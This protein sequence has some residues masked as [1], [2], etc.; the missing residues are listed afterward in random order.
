LTVR[1][2]QR[3][4]G[5]SEQIRLAVGRAV[6]DLLAEG[7]VAFTTVE[8]AERAEVNRRT[9]YRWWPTQELLLIEAL[10]QHARDIEVPDTGSLAR[11]VRAFARRVAVFAADP[12]DLTITRIMVAG[13][14]PEFNNAVTEHFRPIMAGWEDLFARAVARG[15]A[16]DEHEPQAIVAALVSPLFLGPLMSGGTPLTPERVD[17]VA[18]LV[19]AAVAR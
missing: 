4:G 15:E 11:D 17:Q 14:H 1:E 8:V 18:D 13:L 19:L 16:T 7:K 12:V 6:L 10:S 2:R 9:I 3:S 5:R